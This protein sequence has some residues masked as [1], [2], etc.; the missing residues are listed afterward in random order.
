MPVSPTTTTVLGANAF[1]PAAAL[2]VR[3]APL[4]GDRRCATFAGSAA[5]PSRCGADEVD[6]TTVAVAEFHAIA[7]PSL[8]RSILAK[9]RGIAGRWTAIGARD[10]PRRQC[11]KI[12]LARR[13]RW[14]WCELPAGLG[15]VRCPR[16]RHEHRVRIELRLIRPCAAPR[17]TAGASRELASQ[18]AQGGENDD[19]DLL[20]ERHDSDDDTLP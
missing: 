1:E 16:L 2:F 4:H 3:A 13:V 5:G 19:G 10:R 11:C 14:R 9:P 17:F 18:A 8:V 20:R 7:T 12:D 6:P 15:A